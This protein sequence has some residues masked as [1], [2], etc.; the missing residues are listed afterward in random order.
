M[1][2]VKLDITI[3][4]T[5]NPFFLGVGDL[6]VYP[7][8]FNIVSPSLQITP[9]GYNSVIVNFTPHNINL[10]NSENLGITCEGEDKVKLPDGIY[11]IKYTITP[12]YKHS[13][14]RTFIRV[15]GLLESLD[16]LFVSLDIAQ[17]DK[18]TSDSDMRKLNEI[19]MYVQFAIASANKC[20]NTYATES[21]LKALKLIRKYKETHCVKC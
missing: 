12:A 2:E 3:I 13:V 5:H 10:Y 14:E 16:E 1:A 21:Y 6:S 11:K 20:A 8:G 15:D 17:C 9:P 18:A 19:N 4:D 7:N